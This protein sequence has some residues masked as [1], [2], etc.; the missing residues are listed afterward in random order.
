MIDPNFDA[1]QIPLGYTRDDDGRVVTCVNSDGHWY[2]YAGVDDATTTA[3]T[4][5]H[6]RARRRQHDRP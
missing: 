4:Q 5:S 2:T 6:A 1:L 3:N